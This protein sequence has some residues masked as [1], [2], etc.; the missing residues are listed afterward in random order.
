MRP[1]LLELEAAGVAYKPVT[2][3][4]Y[5]RPHADSQAL[6]SSLARRL[7]RRRGTEA[8]VEERRLASRL[9]VAIWERAAR[10]LRQCLPATG[11]DC[12]EEAAELCSA[13]SRRVGA[14]HTVEQE[15]Y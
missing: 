12:E 14:P 2:F 6:L 13:V 10:M 1:Y 9:G 5:R 8:H 3:S 4:C 11:D 7:A 15:A